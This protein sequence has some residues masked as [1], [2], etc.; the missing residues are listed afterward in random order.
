MVNFQTKNPNLDTYLL[1][2]L[3]I[4][5]VDTFYGHLVILRPFGIPI[6]LPIGMFYGHLVY[7]SR[8]GMLHREKKS[9]SPATKPELICDCVERDVTLAR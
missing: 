1:E 7:F 9:G 4:K 6:L 8:F 3:A 2:G 5:H